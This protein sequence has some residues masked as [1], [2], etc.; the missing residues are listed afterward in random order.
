VEQ[1]CTL[2]DVR[3]A[4]CIR[5]TSPSQEDKVL[6]LSR[7]AVLGANPLGALATYILKSGNSEVVVHKSS[8]AENA[9]QDA[10]Q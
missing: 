5:V 8:W 10:S 2:N 4:V 7:P 1:D 9:R 3:S 6:G